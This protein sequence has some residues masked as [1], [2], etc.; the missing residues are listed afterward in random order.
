MAPS[1]WRYLWHRVLRIFPAF[2]AALIVTA[3]LFGPLVTWLEGSS[4]AAFFGATKD[5]PFD[6][7]MIP[8]LADL[9]RHRFFV[10]FW[11]GAVFFLYRDK[12]PIAGRIFAVAFGLVYLIAYYPPSW[13]LL[14]PILNAYVLL[15]LAAVLPLSAWDRVG[16]YSYGETAA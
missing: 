7:I 1:P 14:L 3:F 12:V 16:D 11:A 9:D 8:G 6:W 2:W 13:L 10:S 15:Y 4:L 5:S